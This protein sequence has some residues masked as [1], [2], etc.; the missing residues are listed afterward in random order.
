MRAECNPVAEGVVERMLA[1]APVA[2]GHVPAECSGAAGLDGA[3]DLEPRELALGQASQNAGRQR[4]E[5]EPRAVNCA[6]HLRSNPVESLHDLAALPGPH[7]TTEDEHIPGKPSEPLREAVGMVL[8]LGEQ[9][10]RAGRI[11][12]P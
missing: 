2:A 1:P 5:H 9:D 4:E 3:H 12:R 11:Q 8:S 10:R 7:A 6:K